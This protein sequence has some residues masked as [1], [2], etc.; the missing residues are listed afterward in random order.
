MREIDK[1]KIGKALL[2]LLKIVLAIPLAAIFI[3][4]RGIQFFLKM[5]GAVVSFACIVSAVMLSIGVL[6]EIVLQING[7]GPGIPAIILTMAVAG[8]LAYIPAA[9]VAMVMV[10]LEA[11]CSWIW[12]WYMGNSDN[13]KAFYKRPDYQWSAFEGGYKGKDTDDTE[14]H[15]HYF[16]GIKSQEELKKRYYALLRIYHPDNNFGEDEITRS[17]MEEYDYLKNK[18]PKEE[19][20]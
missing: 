18:F 5:C 14:F 2:I 9:G 15:I 19:S 7:N 4:V 8:G 11:V 12:K 10:V 20:V 16:K 6:V 17:I 13:W 1:K 3:V